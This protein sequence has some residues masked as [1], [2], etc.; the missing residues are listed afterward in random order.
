[1]KSTATGLQNKV[2][3]A[4]AWSAT[5]NWGRMI[6]QFLA[7]LVLSRLLN[8]AAFGLVALATAF[9]AFVKVFLDQGFGLAIIQRA[10][11]EPEHLDTAFWTG[12]MTGVVTTGLGIAGAKFIAGF[13]DDPLLAPILGWISV[14]FV[15][16]ALSNT[17]IS[18]LQRQLSFKSLAASLIAADFVGSVVAVIMALTG[19]GVWSLVAQVVINDLAATIILWRVCGWRPRFRFSPCHFKDL[20]SFGS[21][22]VGARMVNF[23]KRRSD[24]L[25]IGYFMGATAL[26]Y[27]SI[28]YQM[29]LVITRLLLNVINAVALPAFSRLQHNPDEMRR[30]F[31]T[32]TSYAS[33]IAFP[34]FLGLSLM[35][36]ELIPTFYGPQW[37]PSI[38]VLQILGLSGILQ[39][40]FFFNGPVIMAA[41]KPAWNFA[42]TAFQSVASLIAFSIA[43]RWG[44]EAVAIAFVVRG[45]VTA[46]VS[47]WMLRRLIQLD[48]IDFMREHISQFIAS[49]VMVA[50]VL[51]IKYLLGDMMNM[52]ALMLIGISGGMLAYGVGMVLLEPNLARQLLGYVQLISPGLKWPVP[53]WKKV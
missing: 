50:A 29:L 53:A 20:F 37:A 51:G 24:D 2:V 48:L 1:M 17:Q 19:F 21:S 41:G 6:V 36:S 52:I 31:S 10:E 49:V 40:L 43:V 14:S 34:A 16:S 47:I 23:F 28:A 5:Q 42:L 30:A 22:V 7:L 8:P 15:I 25:L 44:I 39:A 18:L 26:G 45:Y 9:T 12:V 3:K 35:A 4:I 46:P 27:Y 33:L 13:F 38:P 11:L 32:A